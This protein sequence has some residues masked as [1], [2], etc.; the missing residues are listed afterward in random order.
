MNILLVDDDPTIS[1][2]VEYALEGMD[3]EVQ[4]AKDGAEG[5]ELANNMTGLRDNPCPDV[6]LLDLNMPRVDG[7]EFLREFRKHPVCRH[8]PVI[9]F[10]ASN[11][12]RD[13]RRLQGLEISGIFPKPVSIED[14][15]PL[16]SMIRAALEKRAA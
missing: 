14:Y 12:V 5:L 10:S 3:A 16:G 9:I 6:V 4:T 7:P 15:R 13:Y 1:Q 2:C 8:V 11:S